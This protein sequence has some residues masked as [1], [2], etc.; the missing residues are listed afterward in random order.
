MTVNSK[1]TAP[2]FPPYAHTPKP[3][4]AN[5]KPRLSR[6]KRHIA[7]EQIEL[8]SH[9]LYAENLHAL[10]KRFPTL[11]R[12][13]LRVTALAKAML[14]NHEIGTRLNICEETVQNHRS[15]IRRK[16]GLSK[17]QSLQKYLLTI[18]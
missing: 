13:E 1:E 2:G 18:I 6:A 8:E 14:K 5:S 16:F 10:A 17:E 15:N 4:L 12:A 7:W 9:G 3:P 11:T